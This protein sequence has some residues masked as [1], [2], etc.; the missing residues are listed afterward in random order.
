MRALEAGM[1]AW[2]E[3]TAAQV[4]AI[5]AAVNALP[6]RTDLALYGEPDFWER[7]GKV[8]SGDCEDYSLEK[9]ARLLAAGV[10]PE[11]LA[12]ALCWTQIDEYHAVL[13]VHSDAGDWVLDNRWPAVT[14][15]DQI[16]YRFDRILQP[17]ATWWR[18]LP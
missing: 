11:D 2:T 18:V 1:I 4:A 9:R 10:P 7:I 5:N 14:R 15:V 8:G 6:Y 3:E 13:I 17:D 12:L 16:P